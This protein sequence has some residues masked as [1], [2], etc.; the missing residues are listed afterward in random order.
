M[1]SSLLATKKV[2][3]VTAFRVVRGKGRWEKLKLGKLKAEI[4]GRNAECGV[5]GKRC[6]K[7]QQETAGVDLKGNWTHPSACQIAASMRDSGSARGKATDWRM[8]KKARAIQTESA[9]HWR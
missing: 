9:Q 3:C 7:R 2:G 1:G 4:G 6:E 8:A 5:G